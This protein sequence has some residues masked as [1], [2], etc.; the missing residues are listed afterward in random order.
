[1]DELTR[2]YHE[3]SNSL[4]CKETPIVVLE[5]ALNCCRCEDM[6]TLEVFVALDFL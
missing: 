3:A 2:E 6:Y 5:D 1:M 4:S